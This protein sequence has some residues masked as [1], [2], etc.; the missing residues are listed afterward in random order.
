MPTPPSTTAGFSRGKAAAWVVYD[1]ANTV[2]AATLTFLFTPWFADQFD[3]Q[4]LGITQ[5]ISMALAAILVPVLGALTD[6]TVKT[7]GYLTIATLACIAA[8]A[9][10]G[11]CSGQAA[12][13]GCFFVA[14]IT[15]NLGLLFYNALLPSVASDERAGLVS[16]IGTGVGYFGTILVLVTLLPLDIPQGQRFVA[17]AAMFLLFALPC[18][19]LVKDRRPPAPG[20]TGATVHDAARSLLATLR[21]LPHH[22]SLLCFLLA[23]FCLVDVLNTAILFFADFTQTAFAEQAARGELA[24]FGLAFTGANATR[25]FVQLAGLC[26][27]VLA[28]LFGVLLGLFTDKHP[29]AVMRLSAIALL[30][31]LLGG[32][33]FGGS[34]PL[35]YLLTLVMLGA[36]GLSGI[37]T[38]GRK[39][40]VLL[41]PRER[42]GEFFGLYGITVKLSVVGSTVYGWLADTAGCKP[43]LLAQGIPIVIGLVLLTAVRLPAPAAA[44]GRA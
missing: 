14:N 9:G 33:A 26:L 21:E 5:T 31:G 43:A 12:I 7:R 1:L 22:R 8:M 19:A 37:W 40:I 32:A 15:Y 11:L 4:S 27:N 38:A 20:P 39:V 13:L 3:R 6:K 17:A 28:L 24:V 41:A 30:C 44:G 18:M 23:N 29:L 10:M 2:Y 42:I 36:L 16:G 34:S 35:G 25:D